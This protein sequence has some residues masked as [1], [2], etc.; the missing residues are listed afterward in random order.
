MAE[1]YVE[2]IFSMD[3]IVQRVSCVQNP[4]IGEVLVC[5]QEFWN[6][7]NPYTVSIV[8]EDNVI[9]GQVPQAISALC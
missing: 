2:E 1:E 9:V 8:C 4:E 7:Y 3:S 5:K 6:L